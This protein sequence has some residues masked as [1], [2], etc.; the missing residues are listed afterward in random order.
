MLKK[1]NR[2]S[3]VEQVTAQMENMIESNQWLVGEKI[4]AE[5]DL[6]VLFDVSRNTLREAIRALVHAGL[7]ETRQGIGTTVKSSSSFKVAVAH[8]IS[9]SDLLETLEVRLALEKEA[10]QLAAVRRTPDDIAQMKIE[11]NNC[12][13]ARKKNDYQEFVKQDMRFHKVIVASAHN[14]MLLNIY[15]SLT[16]A[17][18]QSINETLKISAGKEIENE[19][20]S[21]LVEAII[22]KDSLL[23]GREVESYLEEAKN[24]LIDLSKNK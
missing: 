17:L 21:E 6:M 13:E 14:Q 11:L 24:E 19:I 1:I 12:Q 22:N 7:L 18:R 8:Q 3:L 2:L 10:A 15:E 20:H 5:A 16:D 9:K 23:A 4:P